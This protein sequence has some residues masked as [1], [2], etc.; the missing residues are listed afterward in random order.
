[1]VPDRGAAAPLP[2]PAGNAAGPAP[3]RCDAP[4]SAAA[5]GILHHPAHQLPETDPA[6]RRLL[7]RE[8][9][10]GHAWL[11]VDLEDDEPLDAAALVPAEVRPA[12]PA[13]AERAMCAKRIIETGGGHLLRHCRRHD[14]ARA[15][16]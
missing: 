12:H 8:R 1:M 3:V 16:R 11:G 6:M 7:G 5:R 14:M 4:P 9:G 15:A 10:R 13:A 2:D